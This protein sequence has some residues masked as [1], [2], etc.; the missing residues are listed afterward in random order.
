MPGV[1]LGGSGFG[2]SGM[3]AGVA[4]GGALAS[5]AGV[6]EGLTFQASSS[7]PDTPECVGAEVSGV[8][9]ASAG[10]A[11]LEGSSEACLNASG[12]TTS[13]VCT[14]GAGLPFLVL[15][16]RAPPGPEKSPPSPPFVVAS[17]LVSAVLCL[18]NLLSRYF[19]SLI[20]I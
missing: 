18:L 14:A 3:G 4:T 20:H 10:C 17:P 9:V 12:S 13:L 15:L 7:N 11:F 6:F 5:G 8:A 1:S 2:G 16:R 19:L